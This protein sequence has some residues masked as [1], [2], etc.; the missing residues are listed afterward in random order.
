MF[1]FS[2]YW[3]SSS[4]LTNSNLFQRGWNFNHQPVQYHSPTIKNW[5]YVKPNW[6][7]SARA[8]GG[9]GGSRCPQ[10]LFG[11]PSI[12]S[13]STRSPPWQPLGGGR[14]GTVWSLGHMY[15]YI[16]LY[17]YID[18]YLYI[19][20]TYIYI[21]IHIYIY[22][23]KSGWTGKEWKEPFHSLASGFNSHI[24]NWF[25]SNLAT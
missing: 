3:E 6:V 24:T 5:S 7:R 13:R 17:N 16:I 12:T 19:M 10:I 21:T 9:S 14:C 8:P 22:V 2:I 18:I 11:S 1:Y 20:H 23:Y 4:Q 25:K 15:I